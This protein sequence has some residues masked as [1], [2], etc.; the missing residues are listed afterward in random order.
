MSKWKVYERNVMGK[1]EVVG[2]EKERWK[3]GNEQKGNGK[4]KIEE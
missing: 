4:G 2:K 3:G 1:E